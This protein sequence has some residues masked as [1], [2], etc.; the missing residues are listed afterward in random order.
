MRYVILS[1]LVSAA[2]A[3]TAFGADEPAVS[4]AIA[5]LRAPDQTARIEAIDRLGRSGV[6]S[7]EV[8]LALADL[9]EDSSALIRAH[10]VFALSKLGE[11][12]RAAIPKIV[13]L[14]NDSDVR[15]RRA[16]VRAIKEIRP[17][18]EVSVS[19][20][21]QMMADPDASV[22]L[23][24]TDAIA[25]MGQAALPQLIAALD[26]DEIREEVVLALG[27]MGPETKGAVDGLVHVLADSQN[28][29]EVRREAIMALGE[30]GKAASLA[31]SKIAVALDEGPLRS[32]A[33][34]A[35]GNLGTVAAEAEP[36]LKALLSSDDAF[37]QTIAAWAVIRVAPS[38]HQ[39]V[40]SAA[41][42]LAHSLKSDQRR[43]KEAAARALAD[44][45]VEPEVTAS[46]LETA[47]KDADEATV[48]VALDSLE[49]LGEAGVPKLTEAL[50]YPSSRV[51]AIRV[52]RQLGPASLPALDALVDLL[53]VEDQDVRREAM[54][55]LADM[56]PAAKNAVPALIGVLEHS[57]GRIR[58]A[59][60]YA[61]GRIGPNA[62]AGKPA[63]V[64]L[65]GSE[66]SFLAL[67]AAWALARI[68]PKCER[69]SPRSVPMFV[70]GLSDKDPR[71]RMESAASLRCLGPLA[72]PA[73]DELEQSLNDK[74][75]FVRDM[76]AEA[77]KAIRGSA[78]P[79]TTSRPATATPP[80]RS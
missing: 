28:R 17:G 43:V 47:L 64:P 56:G 35:L 9:T 73:V 19:V 20:L 77:L 10:A 41:E 61:L 11:G 78:V 38:N 51:G 4:A 29:A 14:R 48:A 68:D 62:I 54:F 13:K 49:K 12:A 7:D 59:A 71:V 75:V 5:A 79:E 32:A 8:V 2:I 23:R 57:D 22:R 36:K 33:V 37:L 1:W 34:Y 40:M 60:V 69:S 21:L 65:L 53:N 30:M 6:D 80:P 27:Q 50:R 3:A 67:S 72:L 55:A 18:P 24:A 16:A 58:Y 63:L 25:D 52:L 15:V 44:L 46:V 26:R 39:Q 66:D 76:A 70:A 45:N 74:S 42:V 31:V